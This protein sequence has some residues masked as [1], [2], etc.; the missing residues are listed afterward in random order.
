MQLI[1]LTINHDTIIVAYYPVDD[2]TATARFSITLD[3]QHSFSENLD[4]LKARLAGL[5]VTAAILESSLTY[6][7]SDTIISFNG[8]RVDAGLALTDCLNIPVVSQTAVDRDGLIKAVKAKTAYLDWHLDYYGQAQASRS[9]GQEAMLTVGN[10]Y[11]GLRGA[12]VESHADDDHYPGTYVAGGFDQETTQLKDR[13]IVNEDLVNLPN[14]QFITFGVDHQ[15]P[16]DLAPTEI[17][18]VYH[19]LD[20]KTGILTVTTLIQLAS[21]HQLQVQSQKL[22]NLKHWHRYAIRYQIT[23]LNF[24]GTVQVYSKIDGSVVNSNVSRYNVFDQH[25]LHADGSASQGNAIYLTGH[26]KT[27]HLHYT[28]GASLSSPNLDLIPLLTVT[29][30]T[31]SIQQ[32]VSIPVQAHQTYTFDKNVVITTSHVQD[33]TVDANQEL[34][35][36][37]FD[38]TVTQSQ[39]YWHHRWHNADIRIKGDIMSQRLLWVNLFHSFSAAEALTSGQ[40]DAS[41]GARGLHGE[42]Y[43]G[44][45]F[46]DEMFMLP[47]YALQAPELAKQLLRYRY[48]RLPA[49]RQNAAD[50]GH[51]GA[52]YPWQ[53]AQFG[54]EQ[55]QLVHLNPL[56]D[57][58]DADN[59]RLQRHV[60]LD[61]A[62]NVWSYYHV[63]HDCD[64]LADYGIEMMLSIAAF[65]LSKTHY[66][67]ATDRYD[68]SG[69][70]G[71]DEFHES[72]PNSPTPGLTNNAYTNIMVTW[73]FTIIEHLRTKISA[74]AY[75]K[76][77]KAAHFDHAL[78]EQMR[79]IRQKLSL[80]IDQQG[81]I[82][83]FDGY[84]DLPTLDLATYRQKYGNIARIDRILKATGQTPDAYQVAKQADALMAFYNFDVP[85]VEKLLHQLGYQLP[86]DYLTRNIQYYLARTTHG[87][88]LSRIVYA[89][90]DQLAGHREQAWTLFSEA[91]ISDYD[92]IQGGTTAE[93]IHLGVMC[94]TLLLATRNFGG[95]SVLGNYLQVT[96]QLPTHWHT[97]KFK[98]Q[99]R[100][101]QYSFSMDHTTITVNADHDQPLSI[102]G[103]TYHL[104]ADQP[105]TVIYKQ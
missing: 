80:N 76:A 32:Q 28:I 23:P 54:D 51:A 24:T 67:A 20:L 62:Y 91:L 48:R 103:K 66:N 25:H 79:L 22:A 6:P 90:L 72:Y 104:K 65:W 70:M 84:F 44:H 26:T 61:I 40:L 56:T 17:Q 75:Q 58:W 46:W 60:S 11:F 7:F 86:K 42:A 9:H 55:A 102:V 38:T 45:V 98:Q 27:S 88:T 73:L 36:A 16:F 101:T 105:L 34:A 4:H 94:A 13:P 92:D 87:S 64:F 53:S 74:D 93:G 50:A 12:D 95:V 15:P 63:T 82:A 37:S 83:Q 33:T 31:Q 49:A 30:P 3:P 85:T 1:R 52:M 100:G 99:F 97:L 68:I 18:D 8:T 39:A 5:K 29:E 14:A 19:S 69:V 2:Q 35:Q 57:T 59:S 71:P 43:R 96:P 21:G 89:V 81:I 41:V 78:T 10:G 47:Y 77:A